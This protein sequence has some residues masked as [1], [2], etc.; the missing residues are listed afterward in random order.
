MWSHGRGDLPSMYGSAWWMGVVRA[1]EEIGADGRE[2]RCRREHQLAHARPVAPVDARH[3]VGERVRMHRD[4]GMR[5]RAKQRRAFQ[6][7][8]SIAQG[9]ALSGTGNDADVTR[10][11]DTR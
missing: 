5:V 8:G 10:H 4:L 9:G 1:D 11:D 2:L 7:N 6:A 3:V